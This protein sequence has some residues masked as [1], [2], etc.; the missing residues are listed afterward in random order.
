MFYRLLKLLL[1]NQ[2]NVNVYVA[3][4]PMMLVQHGK[5]TFCLQ[6]GHNSGSSSYGIPFYGLDRMAR[7]LPRL[8][9][10]VI[11]ILLVGHI[12]TPASIDANYIVTNG[13]MVGGTE[14]SINKMQVAS[15]PSQKIFLFDN[16]HG[17]HRE[18]NIHLEDR[19]SLN[20]DKNGILTKYYDPMDEVP[21]RRMRKT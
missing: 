8:F 9:N 18:T 7:K 5:F 15:P 2:K 14:L 21:A 3:E 10:R 1:R 13:S 11:D 20:P 19:V 12:H 6:H 17:I 16:D 4:S